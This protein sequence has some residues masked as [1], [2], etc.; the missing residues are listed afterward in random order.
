MKSEKVAGKA[1]FFHFDNATLRHLPVVAD[2][3]IRHYDD[4]LFHLGLI[5]ILFLA[6]ERLIIKIY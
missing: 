6:M 2:I 1:A 4:C 3:A 5:P